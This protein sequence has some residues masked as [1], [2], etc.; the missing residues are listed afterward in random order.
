M[1]ILN[2]KL[3]HINLA[4]TNMEQA[5]KFY[6]EVLGFKVINRFNKGMEFVFVS[7]GNITYE[8]IEN[9]LL[10]ETII[11]HIAYVSEDIKADYD[12]YNKLG[13][14]T[15]PLGFVDFVYD[16]GV[17]YFFIKGAGNEKIEFCQKG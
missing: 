2:R 6:T 8:L 15:T 10:K 4:V 7:D 16:N 1:H 13:I 5:I 14:T 11:D 9:S 17:H 12:Y 3:D